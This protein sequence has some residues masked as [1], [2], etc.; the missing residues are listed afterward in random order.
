MERIILPVALKAERFRTLP[1]N[2]AYIATTQI[3]NRHSIRVDVVER[4]STCSGYP[5]HRHTQGA[6]DSFTFFHVKNKRL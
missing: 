4:K 5:P 1:R 2:F 6:E 3:D